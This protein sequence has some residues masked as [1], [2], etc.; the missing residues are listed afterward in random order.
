MSDPSQVDKNLSHLSPDFRSMVEATLKLANQYSFDLSTGQAKYPNFKEW[1]V[2]EGYRTVARQEWLY[3]QGRTR[4]GD[5]VTK[6]R[7]PKWHGYGLA[8]D[9]VWKDNNGRVHWDGGAEM[10]KTLGHCARANSLEWG[11]DWSDFVDE[12]HIQIPKTVIAGWRVRAKTYLNGIG[13]STPT[14]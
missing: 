10:W 2:F 5:K 12:P 13:L 3:A 9:I 1:V 8:A 14:G 4:P 6:A 11:G 7:S